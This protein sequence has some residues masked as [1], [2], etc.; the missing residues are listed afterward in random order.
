VGVALNRRIALIGMVSGVLLMGSIGVK[1]VLASTPPKDLSSSLKKD[2][3][4]VVGKYHQMKNAS[5]TRFHPHEFVS[6]GSL[7]ASLNVVDKSLDSLFS[8]SK[9]QESQIKKLQASDSSEKKQ[10]Q[11]LQSSVHSQASQIQ[12]LQSSV[13]QLQTQFAKGSLEDNQV[14]SVAASTMSRTGQVQAEYQFPDGQKFE[15]VGAAFFVHSNQYVLTDDHVVGQQT[16]PNGNGTAI[17]PKQITF[18]CGGSSYTAQ[19][20]K[21]DTYDDLALLKLKPASGMPYPNV[22]PLTLE[23]APVHVGQTAIAVGSPLGIYDS[24]SKGIVS[25]SYRFDPKTQQFVSHGGVSEV[26]I[27]APINEG[28]SGGPVVDLKGKVVGIVDFKLL[29]DDNQ[30]AEGMGVATGTSTISAFLAKALPS[31]H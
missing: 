22:K 14:I 19:V 5:S 10:I 28:N 3:R 11:Q 1:L 31:G 13:T 8:K 12:R 18:I 20:I 17:A 27:D 6:R 4:E 25:D 29:L 16:E 26:Q 15:S 23:T 21:S 24:V 9:S 2:W 7:L 30:P